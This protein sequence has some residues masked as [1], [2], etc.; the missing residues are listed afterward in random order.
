MIRHVAAEVI[1]WYHSWTS[2]FSERV[3]S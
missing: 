3:G 1:L 2:L